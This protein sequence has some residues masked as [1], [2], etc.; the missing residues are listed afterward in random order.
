MATRVIKTAVRAPNMNAIAERLVE[1][2]RHEML[3]HVVV[4]DDQHLARL[5]GEYKDYFNEARPHQGIGQRVPGRPA[6]VADVA[7][8]I[9]VKPMLGGLHHDYRRAA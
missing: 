7:K 9:V 1:S 3:D 4:L 8:P 2:T 6:H 5:T